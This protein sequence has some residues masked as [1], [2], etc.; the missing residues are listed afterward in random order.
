MKDEYQL[1]KLRN[2][3]RKALEYFYKKYFDEVKNYINVQFN[4]DCGS[5]IAHDAFIK[6]WRYRTTLKPK[7]N[8]SGYLTIIAKNLT[9][10]VFNKDK[11]FEK[12]DEGRLNYLLTSMT[13]NYDPEKQYIG[14]ELIIEIKT[15][16][17]NLNPKI[18]KAF[19]LSKFKKLK[20]KEIAD[21]EKVTIKAIE[22]R[23]SKG[24]EAVRKVVKDIDLYK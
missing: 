14:N 20:Y 4:M 10:N 7:S 21:I 2:G 12:C 3:D 19:I 6:L 15:T 8:V 11:K 13:D 23:I 24:L 1:A 22:K 9:I 17:K 18:R 5:D 16:I